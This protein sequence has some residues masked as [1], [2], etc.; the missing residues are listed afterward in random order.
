MAMVQCSDGNNDLVIT[1][2]STTSSSTSSTSPSS[3][4]LAFSLTNVYQSFS[5]KLSVDGSKYKLW[6]NI[7]IDI[8][9]STKVVGHITGDLKPEGANDEDWQYVDSHVKTS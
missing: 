4:T 7:F 1:C 8:C 5:F 6:R 3:G 9:K 2:A